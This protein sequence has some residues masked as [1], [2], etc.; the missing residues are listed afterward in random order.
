MTQMIFQGATVN[1]CVV[2][3]DDDEMVKIWS[4]DKIHG[5][6]EW[7]RGVTQPKRHDLEL[8]MTMVSSKDYFEDVL[9]MNANMV[10]SLQQV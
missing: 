3:E 6:L 4:E 10:I 5:G 9:G 1:E 8:V 7:E 2:K